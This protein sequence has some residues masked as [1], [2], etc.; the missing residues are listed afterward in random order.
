MAYGPLQPIS[1][2]KFGFEQV[3]MFGQP[4]IARLSG[5]G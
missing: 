4:D 1:I 2:I 5:K 3:N